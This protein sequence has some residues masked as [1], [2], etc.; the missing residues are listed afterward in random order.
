MVTIAAAAA[1]PGAERESDA[2]PAG[3]VPSRPRAGALAPAAIVPGRV[4]AVVAQPEE[5]NEPR[6]Q[7]SDVEHPEAD[8]EN[9]PLGGHVS[10]LTPA[11]DPRKTLAHSRAISS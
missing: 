1:G 9:P 8:H 2:V 3:T 6:N 7:E 11:R 4:V 5:P 10:M